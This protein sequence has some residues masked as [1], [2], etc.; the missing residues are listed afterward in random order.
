VLRLLDCRDD[1]LASQPRAPANRRHVEAAAVTRPARGR[2]LKQ[3]R[4]RGVLNRA[5]TTLCSPACCPRSPTPRAETSKSC[6]AAV[7]RPASIIGVVDS[8]WRKSSRCNRATP[9]CRVSWPPPPLTAPGVG[10]FGA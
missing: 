3:G 10:T 5:S 7:R 6:G 9:G 8:C 1:R 4:W 2:L